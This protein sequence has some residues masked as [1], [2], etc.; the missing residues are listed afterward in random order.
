MRRHP[1]ILVAAALGM[2]ASAAAV[3]EATPARHSRDA[4]PAQPDVR[5]E[6][7]KRQVRRWAGVSPDYRARGPQAR[8]RK[9]PNR[10]HV[11]KRTRRAH[12]R[13]RKARR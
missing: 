6:P 1:G 7:T 10:L 9:R 11:S 12:R 2:I 8:K 3:A 4:L 5:V 13:A